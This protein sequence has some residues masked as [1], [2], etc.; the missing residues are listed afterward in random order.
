M[1][2]RSSVFDDLA[3]VIEYLFGYRATGSSDFL[4]KIK[5]PAQRPGFH[6]SLSFWVRGF[7]G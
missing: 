6:V 4:Q 3:V 7:E 1:A 2:S 5:S